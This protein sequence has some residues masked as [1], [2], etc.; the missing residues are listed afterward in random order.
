MRCQ[1]LLVTATL[2][3][4]PPG[5]APG[6]EPEQNPVFIGGAG[7]Y[8]TYRIPALVVTT[9][10]TL[11]A[12]C[13]GR[14]LGRGDAGD[15]D[16][17]LQRSRDGGKTWLDQQVVWDDGANTCGNPCPVVDAQTGIVWLLMTHNLGQDTEAKIVD[18]TS[19][20]TRTVW[21]THST[22][23]GATWAKP[24]DITPAVKPRDWTW[25]ATGPGIGIQLQS[26][27]LVVPCDNKV[28]GTKAQQSHVIYS[29]DRGQTWKLGGVVGPNC[30]ESQLVERSDGSLLLNMRGYRANNRRLAAVSNDGGKTFSKPKEDP[31]LIE[32]VCQAS[33]LRYPGAAGLVLFSNP[34]S[35]KREKLTVRLSDDDGK[36]WQWARALWE[37]P[38]AYS[39]LAVLPDGTL[40]CLYE[41]GE[42]GPYD[43]I[44]L[45]RFSLAWLKDAA[46]KE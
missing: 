3:L 12:F 13:E 33:I 5:E 38:A 4:V 31:T 34:A 46:T 8:H 32:P 28:A 37:G 19:Q 16:L 40:G 9:K 27:R 18:G 17:V 36:S 7:G 25:Y 29:D 26:G 20:A 2:A 6:A 15:V 42:K 24:T 45:A 41:R 35:T 11:L 30:N 22:D 10:G 43:T 21:V 39:C 1:S 14:K 23:E 44:A